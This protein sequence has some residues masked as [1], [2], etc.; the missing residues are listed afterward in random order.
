MSMSPALRSCGLAVLLALCVPGAMAADEAPRPFL[1]GYLQETRVL[2]PLAI[3]EWQAQGEQR[4]DQAELGVA[5]RYQSDERVDRWIDLYF[6]PSGVQLE[7][8]FAEVFRHEVGQVEGARR[9]QG[10][11]VEVLAT[12][13]FEASGEYDA[14]L[15]ELAPKPRSATFVLETRGKRYHSLLAL[16]VKDMY[17]V[18][19]RYSAEADGLSL[20]DVRR[21]GESLLAGFVSSVRVFNTGDCARAMEVGEIPVGASRPDHLLASANDGTDDEIWVSEDRIQMKPASFADEASRDRLFAFAM[22]LHAALRGRCL[23]PES[24]DVDVPDGMREIRI[25]YR[26]PSRPGDRPG[27][28]LPTQAQG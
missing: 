15:G 21:E 22:N 27:L 2:Y 28:R 16:A 13:A 12:Q 26:M 14:L 25:E 20:E 23:P 4:F 19:V 17:Y 8:R 10:D 11:P 18:K 3:G 9:Q 5:V 6:Y 24:M 7:P 1:G